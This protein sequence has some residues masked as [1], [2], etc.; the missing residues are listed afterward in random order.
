MAEDGTVDFGK[1]LRQERRVL[2]LTQETF[3]DQVGIAR[4]TL[5]K[6]ENGE[7]KPSHELALLLVEKIGIPEA[8][9]PAW[10]AFARGQG[11][12]PVRPANPPP[13]RPRTNLPAALTTFIGRQKE[14]AAVIHLI[15]RH[16]LVTLTGS[17]G[18]GK[19][20]LSLQA[21]SNLL[22]DYPLGVW[23]VELAPLN[24]PALVPQAV[25]AAL[26]VKPEGN[27]TSLAALTNYLHS[28]KILLVLD[29]CE[30]LISACAQLC[31][32]LLRACPEL[33]I[34]ASSREA[35]RIFGEQVYRV[36]S[37]S[38]PNSKSILKII[39]S[40]EAVMLFVERAAASRPEF[41]L[42]ESNA[43]SIAR[44]CQRLDGIALAIE[45]AAARLK[46]F[47]VEE[48]AARLDDVF[49]LLSSGDRTALPRQQTLR[50]LIDWSYNLLSEAEKICLRKLAV[51]MGGW[52]LEAAEAVCDHPDA[53][54]LLTQLVEKSLVSVDHAH[55]D[56]ARYALLETI[57]QYALEKLHTAHEYE[58]TRE[59]HL[60]YFTE[61]AEDNQKRRKNYHQKS[62]CRQ[63]EMEFDNFRAA[64]NW[65]LTA[66]RDGITQSRGL[67]TA[68]ALDWVDAS[69]EGLKWLQK[70]ADLMPRGD[71]DFDLLRASALTNAASMLIYRGE[72][73]AALEVLQESVAL[74]E[75]INPAD[76]RG[77]VSALSYFAYA[78]MDTDYTKARSCACQGVAMARGLGEAGRWSL[79]WA[80]F[81]EGWIATRQ[82]EY[83]NA[84]ALIQ[85]GLAIF[86]QAG[87]KIS[88]ADMLHLLARNEEAMQNYPAAYKYY[89]QAR[90]LKLEYGQNTSALH[91]LYDMATLDVRLG[92][93]EAARTKVEACV[94]Y[95][96]DR[97]DQ[98][99]LA[100]SLWGLG[101]ILLNLG[102]IE[103]STLQLRESLQIFQQA[104]APRYKGYG[105]FS[106]A[107]LLMR[108]GRLAEAALLLG[109]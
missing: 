13:A 94:L 44:I 25:C 31:D 23:L 71:P 105:L 9:R 11:D 109:D 33:R 50:A 75:T 84:R 35:L 79:A 61:L 88:A 65:S 53:L 27:T 10:L 51:F 41:E 52:N 67:R 101:D 32:S 104:N 86:R 16:R 19:T 74:Y 106:L 90:E 59:R 91:I 98:Y 4:I 99:N 100:G 96:R 20:R 34:L 62:A 43:L 54:D 42:T 69:A 29:N 107:K 55:G 45:L 60:N 68:S 57:R 7:L 76:K 83:E 30:H 46:M 24:D 47:T 103:Q 108:Q 28:K 78:Y 66:D 14:Q 5:R 17:G 8:E 38:L 82:T 40:S 39:Q 22:A 15:E 63:M 87:D 77:W 6:I 58:A 73:S 64:L 1:W 72:I 85:E 56:A 93:F 2:D 37:L 89:D 70:S 12:L 92:N 80:L 3:A 36:P 81:W 21:A 26:G 95:L 48:I 49:R 102:E 18:V 97:G